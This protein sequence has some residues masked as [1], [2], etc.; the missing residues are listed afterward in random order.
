MRLLQ[1]AKIPRVGKP[2]EQGF[3]CSDFAKSSTVEFQNCPGLSEVAGCAAAC[4]HAA[5]LA[6]S[7]KCDDGSSWEGFFVAISGVSLR[8][9]SSVLHVHSASP[10]TSQFGSDI[11]NKNKITNKKM[12]KRELWPFDVKSKSVGSL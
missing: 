11:I 8:I 10:R 1:T 2:D 12:Y 3:E 7:Y 9:A 6:V 5:E 4:R